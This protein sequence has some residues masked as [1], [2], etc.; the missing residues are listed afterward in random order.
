MYSVILFNWQNYFILKHK[1]HIHLGISKLDGFFQKTSC[2]QDVSGSRVKK[3]Q[4]ASLI[5]KAKDISIPSDQSMTCYLFWVAAPAT[6]QTKIPLHP[7][8]R[9]T[10]F[11]DGHNSQAQLYQIHIV[12]HIKACNFSLNFHS[13]MYWISQTYLAL[14][15]KNVRSCDR[16]Q[17]RKP[18]NAPHTGTLQL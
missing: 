5:N 13:I 6:P 7:Q 3:V 10:C 2:G 9:A 4:P 16:S 8:P 1:K 17:L 15:L 12:P 14:L 18:K 11:F